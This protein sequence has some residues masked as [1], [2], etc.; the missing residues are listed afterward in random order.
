MPNT[1]KFLELKK[2]QAYNI[3]LEL[4][5]G[6]TYNVKKIRLGHTTVINPTGSF[7]STIKLE[8]PKTDNIKICLKYLGKELKS[9]LLEPPSFVVTPH[10]E[11]LSMC[12][13]IDCSDRIAS[14]YNKKMMSTSIYR[15]IL[16][17]IDIN[18]TKSNYQLFCEV[19][20]KNV[21]YSLSFEGIKKELNK[22]K[23]AINN[24]ENIL[25]EIND[26]I[27]INIFYLIE[28][29]LSF[30]DNL[31]TM[32]YFKLSLEYFENKDSDCEKIEKMN[33]INEINDLSSII[34]KE[35]Y[36][37]IENRFDI[38]DL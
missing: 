34:L 24:K 9:R 21:S 10:G 11:S 18:V 33:I 32:E 29:T 15:A 30:Y 19:C 16:L 31:N 1:Y 8:D 27:Y 5:K 37:V 28:S 4:K 35:L 13:C 20:K 2:G 25:K 23:K 26:T 17:P 14:A 7:N 22:I 6:Q 3:K 12:T 38:L 36:W